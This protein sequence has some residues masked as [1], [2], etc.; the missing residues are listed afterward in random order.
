MSVLK[1]ANKKSVAMHGKCMDMSP[2]EQQEIGQSVLPFFHPQWRNI[3]FPMCD[4]TMQT[5]Q[6]FLQ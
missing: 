6:S 3:K 1:D 5:K 4:Y 2:E